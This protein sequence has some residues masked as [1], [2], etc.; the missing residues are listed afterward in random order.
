MIFGLK[1]LKCAISAMKMCSFGTILRLYSVKDHDIFYLVIGL[2]SSI[3]KKKNKGDD[4]IKMVKID[5]LCT[6][7]KTRVP[8]IC[9]T[10]QFAL[11]YKY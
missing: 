11:P 3:F 9:Q 8:S 4:G 10:L 6:H 2:F 7:A 5:P 1:I